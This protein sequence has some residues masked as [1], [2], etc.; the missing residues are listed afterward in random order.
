M[1]AEVGSVKYKV[2]LDDSNL[3]QEASKTEQ[4]LS[5]KLGKA[6]G[7]VGKTIATGFATGAA[8][9]GAMTKAVVDGAK[10]TAAYGDNI[11]KLSQKIGISAEAFQ[12]WDYVF[13]QNGADIS[14]LETG[15]KT[16]SSAVADAGN[17]SKSAQEKFK[18]LGLSFDDLGKM[19]Q[20]DM[21]GAVI[22]QLQQMPEGAERTALASDLLGKSA[23]ELGPLLNQTAEDTQALKDQA[24][25][26]GMIMSDEAVKASADYTDAMDNLTRAFD[27]AKNMLAGEF[28]PGLTEV[29]NGLANLV[30]GDEGATEQITAGFEQIAS[31]ITQAI[32]SIIEGISGLATSI[33]EVAPAILETLANG[34][35]DAIPTLMPAVTDLIEKLVGMLIELAPKLI[36]AGLSI[37]T[38]LALGLGKALPKLIPEAVNAIITIVETLIDNIDQIIDAG[39]AILEGLVEGILNALPTLI[40]K[41]PEII[42]K[43][44]TTLI[45]NL[46]KII[47]CGVKLLGALI[48]GLI[49]S[50]PKL[51][52][53]IPR[54]IS[55]IW[56]TIMHTDW[57]DLG[58]KILTGF[59]DGIKSMFG[60]VGDV[61]G[62]LIDMVIDFF[63]GLPGKALEWGL[64][65]INGFIDGVMGA[66]GALWDGLCDIGSGIVSFLG[67]SVPDKGPLSHADEW[68]PDFVDLFTGGIKDNAYKVTDAVEDLAGDVSMGFDAS[69]SYDVPDI[70][71]YAKDL[72]ASITGTGQTQI[73]VPVILDGR[74]IA[75]ASAWYMGEQLAWE[76]R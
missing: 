18:M 40:E 65:M 73:E 22:A 20:E 7:A 33:A 47:D 26:L 31:S 5:S 23:M 11:D 75:R 8:A 69:V 63:V 29:T 53:A 62:D 57:L 37:L 56:D 13:S 59:V 19:S 41:V 34:L 49:E 36:D 61:V 45:N 16:L 14:I 51:I 9:V 42:E 30:A 39:I 43:L 48:Q 68:G 58:V 76:A 27:G 72:S 2:E 52:A 1:S 67:F 6:A 15:M 35:I 32:P 60:S 3:D 74:E 21:F 50:I 66:A 25:D 12:E 71:G 17:G 10:E 46:P 64:D 38:Q 55:A 44:I 28:L 24:H 4:T 70:A 54:I